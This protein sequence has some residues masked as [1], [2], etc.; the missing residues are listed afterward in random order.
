MRETTKFGPRVTKVSIPEC[1]IK[2]LPVDRGEFGERCFNAY[3]HA[4]VKLPE[5]KEQRE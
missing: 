5:K 4:P 3:E 2:N 1:S